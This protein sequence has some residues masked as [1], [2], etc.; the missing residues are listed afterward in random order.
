SFLADIK[1]LPAEAHSKRQPYTQKIFCSLFSSSD[2]MVKVNVAKMITGPK[3]GL[4][5]KT[6]LN[7]RHPMS[8]TFRSTKLRDT[9]LEIDMADKCL[10]DEGLC[11]FTADLKRLLEFKNDKYPDG[12]AKLTGL[13]L[14]GNKLTVSCLRELG[15]LI[16]LSAQDLRELN[17]SNNQITIK[18]YNSRVEAQE[19]ELFLTSFSQCCVL[20]KV[21]FSDN[22]IGDTGM[23]IFAR[24]YIQSE[25]DFVNT[26]T[27]SSED[28]GRD[29]TPMSSASVSGPS[30]SRQSSS[31]R[32]K[33]SL[34]KDPKSYP[35]DD[36][37]HWSCT[38]GLQSVPYIILANVDMNDASVVHLSEIIKIRRTPEQLL[39]YLPEGKSPSLPEIPQHAKKGIYWEQNSELS[40]LSHRLM[41]AVAAVY[42]KNTLYD[43]F[44]G[45]NLEE[46]D[47]D[48]EPS[49]DQVER[50]Q[51]RKK[52][53]DELRRLESQQRS[54]AL[55]SGGISDCALWKYSLGLLM[56]SRAILLD[57]KRR[58]PSAEKE[59]STAKKNIRPVLAGNEIAPSPP[60]PPTT[61]TKFGY[62]PTVQNRVTPPGVLISSM[63]F[64]PESSTFD[65]MFPSMHA[66]SPNP[67]QIPT[68]PDIGAV[69][70]TY[71]HNGNNSAAKPSSRQSKG[72]GTTNQATALHPDRKAL[73]DKQYRSEYR[74]GLPLHLWRR[75]ITMSSSRWDRFVPAAHQ[76]RILNYAA[77]WDAFAAELSVDGAPDNQ[78]I[79]RILH[80]MN[81]SVT[82]ADK[83]L[84]CYRQSVEKGLGLGLANVYLQQPNT[85]VILTTRTS[86]S[87]L[88]SALPSS[89]A[90][91]LQGIY[92][93]D[94][95]STADAIALREALLAEKLAKI[96][97]VIANA[98]YGDPFT[99]V[100]DAPIDALDTL[101]QV[102]ALGPVRLYQQLWPDFLSKSDQSPKFLLISSAL[103]SIQLL[104]H[105][106]CAGYAAAKAAGNLFIKKMHL[107]NERLVTVAL[108]PG[109]VQTAN[110]QAYAD[111]IGMAG[112]PLTTDE[113]VNAI[114]KTVA[115]AEKTTTSG[116]F[117]DVM[118]GAELPW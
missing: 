118:R 97:I 101:Y 115:E 14:Q 108:H 29:E 71:N 18:D 73:T 68:M 47:D 92:K 113:S 61:T 78:Q 20:K 96:D 31:H 27:S 48:E 88:C 21:D 67:V 106:P 30:D 36:I 7:T 26:Y 11:M 74:F 112:P 45:L 13:N 19:W 81:E 62:E 111:A 6:N 1:K 63:R 8:D 41:K 72:K 12:I 102:N 82:G 100:L 104:D 57:D 23:D 110:G 114:V 4:A 93:L 25:L 52:L 33:S 66:P 10:T 54:Q 39:E 42:P 3:A 16:R 94:S 65:Y 87:E 55:L 17:L 83:Q 69:P 80:N 15:E 76:L 49:N 34:A 107:E 32:R 70:S 91:T 89:F 51:E 99:T 95:S 84:S 56:L 105:T 9:L 60:P 40:K 37:N 90:G 53:E 35:P 109:W 64:D 43:D 98:G 75:I 117:I 24:V 103:A 85:K 59:L 77:D 2:K 38:R 5:M 79:S 28:E 44:D 116:K 46:Y 22:S 86:P 50:R 58:P